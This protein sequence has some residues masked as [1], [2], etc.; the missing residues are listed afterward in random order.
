MISRRDLAPDLFLSCTVGLPD[1]ADANPMAAT[2]P[3]EAGTPQ[4]LS[5]CYMERLGRKRNKSALG[6]FQTLKER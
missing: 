3:V 6:G 5:R 4:A 1:S 2:V